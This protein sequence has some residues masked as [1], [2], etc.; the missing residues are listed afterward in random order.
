VIL[1]LRNNLNEGANANGGAS[2]DAPE[3]S[4]DD[5]PKADNRCPLTFLEFLDLLPNHISNRS[6]IGIQYVTRGNNEFVSSRIATSPLE[7]GFVSSGDGV[8]SW[9]NPYRNRKGSF[10]SFQNQA[11]FGFDVDNIAD[12]DLNPAKRISDSDRVLSYSDA[13][14]EEKDKDNPEQKQ[15]KGERAQEG[16]W[17]VDV[18]V[19]PRDHGI[20]HNHCSSTNQ[21]GKGSVLEILH[22]LSLTEEEVG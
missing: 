4:F 20:D 2:K 15:I 22:E 5:W 9:S 18:K 12:T 19:E 16:S 21:S 14:F 10:L 1:E 13:G 8:P 11:T 6:G 17:A 3:I 7:V